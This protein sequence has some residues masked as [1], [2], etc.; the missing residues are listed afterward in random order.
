MTIILYFISMIYWERNGVNIYSR[1]SKHI[2]S[3]YKLQVKQTCLLSEL[4]NWP[5]QFKLLS[6]YRK[7]VGLKYN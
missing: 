1:Q 5:L 6:A 7:I 3:L 2:L 4:L